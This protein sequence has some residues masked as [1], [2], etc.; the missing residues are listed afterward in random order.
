MALHRR[1]RSSQH[2]KRIVYITPYRN[3]AVEVMKM[4]QKNG[5]DAKIESEVDKGGQTLFVVY[6]W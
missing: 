5:Y 1:R 4:Y 3:S 6:V 2:G